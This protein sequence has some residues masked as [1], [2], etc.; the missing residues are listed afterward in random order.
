MGRGGALGCDGAQ[1]Q[2]PTPVS[3]PE[4]EFM[5]LAKANDCFFKYLNHWFQ[6]KVLYTYKK[7]A[8]DSVRVKMEE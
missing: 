5:N 2:R 1:P 6:I 3:D 7:K 4:Y 8:F